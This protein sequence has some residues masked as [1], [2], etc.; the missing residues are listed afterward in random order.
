MQQCDTFD[1][2]VLDIG[3]RWNNKQYEE[4]D[5]DKQPSQEELLAMM[6]RVKDQN[7]NS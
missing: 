5:S 1:L 4:S 2:L 7:A 6:Q 3:A